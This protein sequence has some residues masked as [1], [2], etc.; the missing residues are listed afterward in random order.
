MKQTY[1]LILLL[2]VILLAN[3]VAEDMPEETEELV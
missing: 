1:K 2:G 3:T